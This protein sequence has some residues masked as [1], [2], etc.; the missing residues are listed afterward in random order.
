MKSNSSISAIF[1]L[2]HQEMAMLLGVGV[3]HYSMFECGKRDLP[4]HAKLLLTD[5]LAQMQMPQVSDNVEKKD[6]AQNKLMQVLHGR[7]QKNLLRSLQ[8][9]EKIAALERKH[10]AFNRVQNV[11]KAL[12]TASAEHKR[13][14]D[15]T[16]LKTA[17][18][19]SS[20]IDF[21]FQLASLKLDRE[22]FE[23]ERKFFDAKFDE[24]SKGRTI[25]GNSRK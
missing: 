5:L 13:S 22:W 20:N 2:T 25:N 24:I 10:H 7:L 17:V 3:S 21:E 23:A 9:D 15:H 6:A 8:L 18:K 16:I 19:K 4:P 11:R 1:G 14:F 12:G